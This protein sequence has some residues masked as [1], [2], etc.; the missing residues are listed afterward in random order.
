MTTPLFAI[1]NVTFDSFKGTLQRPKPVIEQF[2]RLGSNKTYIQRIKT[3]APISNIECTVILNTYEECEAHVASL[4][5]WV[6]LK[7]GAS[8]SS[9][10]GGIL[11]NTLY[12]NLYVLDYTY[13]IK[14]YSQEQVLLTYQIQIKI[15]EE[16]E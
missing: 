16:E 1:E 13:S 14:V 6:G 11:V 12:T 9:A 4:S 3:E 5:E 15:D 10:S 7:A 8:L 2:T